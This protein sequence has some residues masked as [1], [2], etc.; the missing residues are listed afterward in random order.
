MSAAQIHACLLLCVVVLASAGIASAQ[1]LTFLHVSDQHV[2]HALSQTQETMATV[3]HGPIEL[4]PYA[5][6]TPAPSFVLSTGDFNE[7]SGG[8]GWWEQYL[9]L[10][11]DITVP[12]YHQAG[13]HD[14]TW[15]CARP[16]LREMHG[17][18]FYA[19]E[20]AG[21]KFIGWDTATP[22]DPRPSIG[23]EGI[24]WLEEEFAQTPPEQPV[25]VFGHHSLDGREYAGAYDRARLLDLLQ[26]RNVV[27]MLV[28]HGH[29]AR[30]WQVAGIDTVMGGSTFGKRPGFGVVSIVD[31]TLRVC[32]QY[33]DGEIAPLLEKPIPDRS[34]F[35]PM[36]VLPPD[37][38]VLDA[39]EA[40]GW[41]ITAEEAPVEARWT[42]D[43][44]A[45]G[46]M[47]AV[48]DGWRVDLDPAAVEPGAHSLRLELV[49]ADGRIS[50]RTVGF[51]RNGGAFDVV[52]RRRLDGSCQGAPLIADGRL[53]VGDNSGALTIL[54]AS[55]GAVVGH[56]QTGGEVRSA[57]V[58]MPGADT[59]I[60]GSA[61]GVLR[62]IDPIGVER[63]RYDAGSALYGAPL[64]A[65]GRVYVGTA[66]G[67]VLALDAAT[68]APIWSADEPE[69]AFEQAPAAGAGGIFAGSWDRH[70]YAFDAATGELKWRRPSA[71][72]DREGFVAW[73]YSPA[74][75]PPVVVGENVFFADRAYRLTVFD[76][77]SGERLF[78]EAKSVA[79]APSADGNGAYVRHTDHRVSKRA[80][81]GSVI[82]VAEVPTGAV[83]TPP[84]EAH[85][86]LWV[87]SDRGVLSALDA[88]SG[89][90]IGQERVTP[91]IYGFAAP[92]FDG[93]RVFVADMAGQVTCLA[94][95]W[96]ER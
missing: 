80:A 93:E 18:A 52:W 21:V 70:A 39:D 2:P 47:L 48:G 24:R 79:V 32:H 28:G 63:W 10:W 44:D 86:L 4:T 43:G 40:P 14:N 36:A 65:D 41:T 49:A 51:Y 54:D 33:T 53:F 8:N 71:G 30:A 55:D 66:D 78:D 29:N 26:T 12:V 42:L 35:I 56:V 88:G 6:T 23:E 68:G 11:E 62:A 87:I 58:A 16:H 83:P 95:D 89:R 50:S 19:F 25:I 74:D 72:S 34:P 77:E 46:E 7:F 57:P 92:A 38:T 22:Q 13:N 9:S 61:D 15:R 27:L 69:Y 75:C 3:P 67:D 76:A 96:L 5:I 81:D 91:D 45:S 59:V 94:P 20:R 82:W 90:L 73:Y 60:F 31:G 85:G 84:V 37:G 17:S 1:D 64:I